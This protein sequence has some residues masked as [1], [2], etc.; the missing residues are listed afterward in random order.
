MKSGQSRKNA[1]YQRCSSL[2]APARF[3]AW[4][5]LV[6]VRNEWTQSGWGAMAV[7]IPF[8]NGLIGQLV[9]ACSDQVP[10]PQIEVNNPLYET[11]F[12]ARGL[13]AT[14]MQAIARLL[15]IC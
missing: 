3:S 7:I 5:V 15:P 14:C 13:G 11:A 12:W 1:E 9:S 8:R 4:P 6:P 2:P 10:D